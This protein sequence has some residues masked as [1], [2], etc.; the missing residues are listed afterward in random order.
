V[1]QSALEEL[2]MTC[3]DCIKARK[4]S[5]TREAQETIS[6]IIGGVATASCP[7]T[8]AKGVMHLAKS[9]KT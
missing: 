9:A 3:I 4:F 5:P 8:E 1:Q 7:A 6:Y 2:L